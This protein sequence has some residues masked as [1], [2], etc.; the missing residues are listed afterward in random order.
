L[1]EKKDKGGWGGCVLW[2][3]GGRGAGGVGGGGG[4]GGLSRSKFSRNN[5]SGNARYAG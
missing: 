4:G 3:G 2:F 1:V 5:S